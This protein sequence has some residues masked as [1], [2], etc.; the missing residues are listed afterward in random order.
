M[1]I[2]DT[3]L[4]KLQRLGS[5]SISKDKHDEVKA[6]LDEILGFV[7]NLNSLKFEEI[8]PLSQ[9][10]TPLRD[11]V[12]VDSLIAKD[13]LNCAPKAQEGFFIVPKIIE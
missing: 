3:T 9:P 5:I 6:Q 12:V 13:V 7:E 8:T 10:K 1:H 4:A 11:D 2:D